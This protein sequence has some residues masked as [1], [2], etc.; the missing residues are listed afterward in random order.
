[1]AI[2]VYNTLTRKKEVFEAKNE[3]V[4]IY[5]CGVTP[6]DETH[7]GHARPSVIWDVIKKY[8]RWQGYQVYHVQNFTD[9]DDKIIAR[10][11]NEGKTAQEISSYYI[12]D[13]LESMAALGVEEADVYPKVS[14]HIPEI[15][16]L[17]EVL[18]A[19][20]HAYAVNGN[21]FFDVLSF[22]EYGKLSN[23]KLDQLQAGTRFEVD[24]DKRN[25]MDFALW[26]AAKPGEPAWDSPWGKGRPG[27]HIE[28]SAMSQKYLGCEFEF[29]GGGADLVFPHHE[30]EIAQSEAATSKPLAKYW[31]HNG[32]LNLK[33][34]KMSKSEGNF[35]TVKQVLAKY[36]KELVRFYILSNHYRSELEFHDS[37]L[38]EVAR[39]WQR[40]NDCVQK[41]ASVIKEQQDPVEELAALDAQL[42]EAVEETKQQF[43]A[44]MND[45]F[46]TALAIANLFELQSKVNSYLA[47]FEPSPMSNCV[48]QQVYKLFKQL[49]GDIL[50]VLKLDSTNVEGLTEPLMDLILRLRTELRKEKNYQLADMIRD[51]LEELNILVED[52]PQGPRWKFK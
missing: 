39:G 46:N 42:L 2:Q 15:I 33:N 12:Q 27:W 26:K 24:P 51:S 35:V 22:P 14:E 11:L 28:C 18:I 38:D 8:L 41:V 43:I 50:G 20:G 40:F 36:P 3:R 32:M 6:Y 5:V 25:P 1:V 4:N 47:N 13:Y 17:I 37:K 48:L 10:A 19:K 44:A 7:L 45:D 9:I 49:A 21:V 16:G 30:N 29:H 52:T 23:Q 31:L 34:A